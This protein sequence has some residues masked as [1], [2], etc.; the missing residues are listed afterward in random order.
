[1]ES[2]SSV[3]ELRRPV[4][5]RNKVRQ[6]VVAGLVLVAILA[7]LSTLNPLI[8]VLGS[9]LVL[10]MAI[11]IPRPILI[12]YG[13]TL[14]L[15]LTGGL[16]RG[17]VIPVL[18]VGQA[19]LVLGFIFFVLAKPSRLGKYR[20][21][22]IDL[23][24]AIFVLCEAVF[25][26]LA[27]YYN[28]DP[29][30][31][32]AYNDTLGQSPLQVLLGPI[33]YYV[34]YR[35]I[36]ATVSSDSQIKK[37]L[38][39]SFIVSIIVSIIGILEKFVSPV[40]A[41]I[42]ANYPPISQSATV[43]D[44]EL[45]IAS[46]LQHFSGLGAYLTFTLILALTCYTVQ[47]QMKISGKLLAAT[48]LFDSIALVLTGTLAA[49]IGLAVG[50]AAVFLLI[51]R[52]PKLVILVLIGMSLAVIIFQPFIADRLNFEFGS[53]N[54]QGLIPESL[55]FRIMLWRQ[56]FLPAIAQNL[57]FGAGPAPTALISWPAEESQYFFVLLRGGLPY[58]FSY[59]L[60]LG[61][62]I[63]VCWRQLK[64]KNDDA[65]Q[66]V[67]IALI[68]IIIS[69][70]VMNFSG[71]YFTYVGGTQTIWTLLA[72]VE[73]SWQLKKLALS[74]ATIISA[75]RRN[76]DKWH[77]TAHN[78]LSNTRRIAPANSLNEY[79]MVSFLTKDVYWSDS[80][81]LIPGPGYVAQE[82]STEA[83]S[84]QRLTWLMRL[85]DWRFVKDSVI[86]G[87]GSTISRVLGLLF[88]TILAHF[89]I[90]DDFGYVRYAVILAGILTIAVSNSPVS[91]TR[92][93][94]AN[95]NDEKARDRYFT[96]GL[97]GFAI[98]LVTSLFIAVPVL[99]FMHALDIGTI[100]CIIGL[101]GF[102]C[103]LA[104]VRGLNNAWKMGLT[105]VLNN[106][107]LVAGLVVIF[108]LFKI[109]TT[110][111][112]LVIYGLSNLAPLALELFRPMTLR[113][114]FN[115]IS[116][117]TLLELT[118][119]AIPVVIS[120]GAFAIWFGVDLLLVQNFSPHQSGSYAAA[121]T[122]A[123]VYMFVPTAITMVLMPRVA[124]LDLEKSK[125]YVV[126]GALIALLISLCGFE[127][128]YLDGP[129]IITIAFGYR[130]IDAYLPL[131]VLSVGMCIL[132]VYMVFEGFV[133]GRGR[134]KLTAQAL[135]V[136]MTST[137]VC[138]F[139][140]VS[141]L[142][143]IGASLAFT[144]GAA[145]GLIVMLYNTWLFLNEEKH[146]KAKM[147]SGPTPVVDFSDKLQNTN[148]EE[149]SERRNS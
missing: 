37:I 41:F 73:A 128:I 55:A 61:T 56:L 120:S 122:L 3:Q 7:G 106:V 24:F 23:V 77:E 100:S 28:G 88:S 142:G 20:L 74:D 133:I 111:A 98:V 48:F 116:R 36:V 83:L 80:D 114:H 64:S 81:S 144:I 66:P 139:W 2:T 82:M 99:R 52:I 107:V 79:S 101:A 97:V 93:L 78:L 135:L 137:I 4:K 84:N 136:A 33:Q 59:L 6:A 30:N 10:L 95:P 72:I 140:L 16:A 45:R 96:N 94:A 92:F 13:L 127:I 11:L 18:R 131:V 70:S 62:A 109:R 143:P 76:R 34:L 123:Q 57:L 17:A 8:G 85:L 110:V 65:S 26:V 118:R 54:A 29:L 38:E 148:S 75:V 31:L 117:K 43:S 132:S 87:F 126:G 149:L 108:E 89:L 134:P 104:I 124:A 141:S 40:R 35:I 25:P 44:T 49:W 112:A 105:Y 102:Y 12:V 51:R 113:F 130:Y 15:P 86:V 46:T 19:L 90:P 63:A 125:R 71:E 53:G 121:K 21:T 68:A 115:L 39:L 129:R 27:L 58:F 147:Q 14:A 5:Q 42:V 9:L 47:G 138:S 60:L 69:I 67:A 91:I 145:F 32:F 1:M 50:V 103:Y 146:I 22:V 119:F